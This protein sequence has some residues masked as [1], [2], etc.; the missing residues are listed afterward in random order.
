MRKDVWEGIV[1][2]SF[3]ALVADLKSHWSDIIEIVAGELSDI[4][5]KLQVL[6]HEKI[7]RTTLLFKLNEDLR[8]IFWNFLA[9]DSH[10][11]SLMQTDIINS[12]LFIFLVF[13]SFLT[14]IIFFVSSIRR[15][16]KVH[17]VL[18]FCVCLLELLLLS[19]KSFLDEQIDVRC[20]DGR[21]NSIV[22]E[23]FKI[24]FFHLSFL[25]EVKILP[26]A[27]LNFFI[28]DFLLLLSFDVLVDLMSS[29]H[30]SHCLFFSRGVPINDPIMPN[31]ISHT[32]SEVR[33]ELKNSCH[34]ILELRCEKARFVMRFVLLPEK[35]D[36]V[37][38][39]VLVVWVGRRC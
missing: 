17:S 7:G 25:C 10:S 35:V 22:W 8:V 29:I 37:F 36:T 24:N 23:I 4:L 34:Q 27:A 32:W 12:I 21:E 26:S 2:E 39:E 20:L 14:L 3:I 31:D 13:L 18:P 11:A 30:L 28:T 16:N 9:V 1:L 15:V 19:S 33:L 5:S 6:L 38:D